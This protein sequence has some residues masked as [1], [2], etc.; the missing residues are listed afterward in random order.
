MTTTTE[1]PTTV[2]LAAAAEVLRSTPLNVLM[3]IKRGLLRGSEGPAGWQVEVDSLT[4]L[5]HR[6]TAETPPVVCKSGCAK[7]GNCGSS[8]G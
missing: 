5:L 7:S 3:H 2:T 6:R 8:C 1:N 4:D